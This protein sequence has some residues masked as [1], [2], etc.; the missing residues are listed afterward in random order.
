VE[1]STYFTEYYALIPSSYSV[2]VISVILPHLELSRIIN[3][4]ENR[5]LFIHP[6]QKIIASLTSYLLHLLEGIFFSDLVGCLTDL[7]TT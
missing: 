2:H 6:V 7:K 4:K 3:I 1:Y 5:L